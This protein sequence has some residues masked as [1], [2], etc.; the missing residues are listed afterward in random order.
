MNHAQRFCP[1]ASTK[2]DLGRE[3]QRPKY[4]NIWYYRLMFL[5]DYKSVNSLAIYDRTPYILKRNPSLHCEHSHCNLTVAIF[6]GAQSLK[7]KKPTRKNIFRR[8]WYS[9]SPPLDF[10]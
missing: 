3:K 10:S 2:P 8:Q 5:T 1:V 7:K 9:T 6:G 4:C